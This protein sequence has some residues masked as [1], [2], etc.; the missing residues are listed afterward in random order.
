[1]IK[2]YEDYIKIAKENDFNEIFTRNEWITLKNKVIKD[3]IYFKAK[4]KHDDA[5]IDNLLLKV[6]DENGK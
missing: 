6:E 2:K 1:M 5:R 4:K 3:N